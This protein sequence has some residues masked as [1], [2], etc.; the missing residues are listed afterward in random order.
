MASPRRR[1]KRIVMWLPGLAEHGGIP[2]H[3]RN[4]SKA[5][6]EYANAHDA[7]V[8]IV[9]LRDPEGFY[10]PSYM[11]RPLIGCEGKTVRFGLECMRSIGRA[12]DLLVVGVVDFGPM[13]PVAR[14]RSPRAS[15]L[16]ITHGIEVWKALP[17][18]M[19][20]A[21]TEASAVISVSRYTSDFVAER[22]GVD[23]GRIQVI[24][25]SMDPEFLAKAAAPAEPRVSSGSKLLSISRL[26]EIDAPKGVERVIESLPT[27]RRLI[28]AVEYTVIGTGDDRARLESLAGELGVEDICDFKGAVSDVELHA[29]LEESDLFVLPSAKEGFGIVFLE[30]GAHR[31]AVVGADAG[32]TPEVVIDGVTGLLVDPGDVGALAQAVIELL[33]DQERRDEMG[34]EGER[35]VRDRYGYG[36]VSRRTKDL[37]RELIER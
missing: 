6:S 18:R 11:T 17:W 14:L 12:Y 25:P 21:L 1:K 33:P 16:T 32:A 22:H 29:D 9:S 5:V 7:V 35:Q 8:T 31:R 37:L 3:N 10:D 19:R 24:P 2:R 15:I 28:P 23:R 26:N 30:A 13:V 20:V 4:F 36:S 27:I 34:R